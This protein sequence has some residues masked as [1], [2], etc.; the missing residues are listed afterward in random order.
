MHL[1]QLSRRLP[2]VIPLLLAA[3]V[4]AA[5]GRAMAAEPGAWQ[6]GDWSG[7]IVHEAAT[8]RVKGCYTSRAGAG[9]SM[10]MLSWSR[11]GLAVTLFDPRWS[12]SPGSAGELGLAVDRRWNGNVNGPAL[13]ARARRAAIADGEAALKAL[14]RG[15]TL[16]V[17][18]EGGSHSFPL[19]GSSKAIAAMM[20]CHEANR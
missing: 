13:T 9:G 6:I 14:R 7:G 12:L 15:N 8:G 17:R 11:D 19:K 16:V 5:P 10:V 4:V 20:D 2:V 3:V 18:A 1:R